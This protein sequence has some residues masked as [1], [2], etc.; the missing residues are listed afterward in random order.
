MWGGSKESWRRGLREEQLRLKL[1]RNEKALEYWTL[2][3]LRWRYWNNLELKLTIYYCLLD[4]SLRFLTYGS[5]NLMFRRGV[6]KMK[7][8]CM[9]APSSSFFLAQLWQT[10]CKLQPWHLQTS[11]QIVQSLSYMVSRLRARRR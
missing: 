3:L 10:V 7:L 1:Y 4:L 9:L 6:M 2:R 8:I 11:T 5:A